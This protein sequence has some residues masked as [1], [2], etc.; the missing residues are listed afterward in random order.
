[1]DSSKELTSGVDVERVDEKTKT[2][3]MYA[4]LGHG[5]LLPSFLDRS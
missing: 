2:R 3:K 1:V 5:G 4:V